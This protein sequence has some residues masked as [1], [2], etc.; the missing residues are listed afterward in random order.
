MNMWLLFCLKLVN[1]RKWGEQWRPRGRREQRLQKDGWHHLALK[2]VQRH[3]HHHRE[4]DMCSY[5]HVWLA[6]KVPF[7]R[8][9]YKYCSTS[10]MHLHPE[11]K[12]ERWQ[13][14]QSVY[15]NHRK[16]FSFL[17][18][19]PTIFISKCHPNV[20][21]CQRYIYKRFKNIYIYKWRKK[22]VICTIW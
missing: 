6:G 16:G 22:I 18:I 11:I 4:S 13:V 20:V 2:A 9:K 8:Y 12:E 7:H 1:R 19:I 14:K 5:C 3:D 17:N 10:C 21:S 15:G